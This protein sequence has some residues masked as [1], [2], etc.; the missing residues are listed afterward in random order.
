M[1]IGLLVIEVAKLV[2]EIA[3][4]IVAH[5]DD[6]ILNPESVAKVDAHIVVMN[7]HNPIVEVFVVKEWRPFFSG[8]A[9]LRT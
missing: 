5:F 1:R 7:F 4:L 6:A 8:G 3:I 9:L 2:V